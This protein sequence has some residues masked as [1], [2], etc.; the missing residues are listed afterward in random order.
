MLRT[1]RPNAS[2]SRVAGLVSPR[3][4]CRY[5]ANQDGQTPKHLQGLNE[6]Q[7]RGRLNP[8][9]DR[10][11]VSKS[12]NLLLAVT[13]PPRSSLQILAGPGTGKTRVLTSRTAEL[14]LGHS[15]P[16]SSIAALTF[17][18]KASREMKARLRDYIGAGPTEELKLGTFHS[19]CG[20]SVSYRHV[21]PII[22]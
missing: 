9:I 11:Y 17:T 14:V 2:H 21:I 4:S 3:I 8:I 13:F 12:N 18:R 19:V 6:P 20:R 7:L 22:I 16:P 1:L 15:Y 5:L 10:Q